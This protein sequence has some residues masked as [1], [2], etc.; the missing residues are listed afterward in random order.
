MER[1]IDTTGLITNRK[2]KDRQYNDEK[3]MDQQTNIIHKAL[4]RKHKH[5]VTRNLGWTQA[6]SGASSVIAPFASLN[7]I[8]IWLAI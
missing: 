1:L 8:S 5:W 4:H 6:H 2:G 3:T 7:P